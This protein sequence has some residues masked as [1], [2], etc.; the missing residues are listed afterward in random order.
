MA[1]DSWGH[2]WWSG[3]TGPRAFVERIAQVLEGG[4]SAVLVLPKTCPWR[5]EMRSFSSETVA[6]RYGL[7]R[8]SVD[9]VMLA[10]T[11][12]DA[13]AQAPFQFLLERYALRDVALRYR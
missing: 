1:A 2:A 6:G 5:G 8:L 12:P 3:I 10:P 11:P 7:E 4:R 9:P 13:P